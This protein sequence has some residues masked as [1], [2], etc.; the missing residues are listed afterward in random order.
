M[1]ARADGKVN[2][3]LRF[4]HFWAGS[5]I[6]ARTRGGGAVRDLGA[7]RELVDGNAYLS[8]RVMMCFSISVKAIKPGIGVLRG[9][10]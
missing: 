6:S 8:K 7:D 3:K 5:S 2:V 1:H 4:C 10:V 9:W